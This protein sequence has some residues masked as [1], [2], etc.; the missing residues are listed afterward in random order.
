MPLGLISS[1][2]LTAVAFAMIH[3]LHSDLGMREAFGLS[4]DSRHMVVWLLIGCA[5]GI[6]LGLF[7]RLSDDVGT[8]PSRIG[9]FVFVA[10]AIGASEELLFRGYIQGGLRRLGPFPAV[11]LASTAHTAYK[12]SLFLF[13]PEGVAVDR[14]FLGYCTLGAGLAA[15]ALRERSRSVVPPLAGHVLFDI[16]VYGERSSAPWWVWS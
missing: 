2:G 8:L 4:L 15:G 14:L 7:S 6:T 1:L 9:Q 11:V 3:S 5:G 12:V 16:V 13:L 10:S